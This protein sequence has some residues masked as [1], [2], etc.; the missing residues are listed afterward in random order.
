VTAKP[1]VVI[2]SDHLLYPSETFIKAQ[3]SA[4][5]AYEPVFAGSRRVAGL[6]LPQERVYTVNPG[7]LAGKIHE[8][9]FKI[10]GSAPAMVKQLGAL[11]PV[12]LHAHYGPNG[13]RAMPLASKLR[14]PL[15][16]TFHGSDIAITDLR[17]QKT[18]FGFRNYF[19]NKGKLKKSDAVFL[20]V[21]K[22]VQRKLLEQGFPSEKIFVQYTGVDT[23]K[24]RP[25][26]TEDRPIILFVGRLVEFKGPEFL[27]RAASEVQRQFPAVEVVLIGDGPLRKDL[28]RLAKQSLRCFTFL[29]VRTPEEVRD[30]MNRASMLC[31]PSVTMRSGEA[32]GYGMVCAEA[33]AVGKPV[34]A[35][36]SG[37][38]PE[39]ISHGVTGF[40]A[41]EHDWQALARNLVT[42]LQ[43][44]ELRERFGRSA[45]E[46]M[47]RQF[48]LEQCTRQL[49]GVYGM[50][51]NADQPRE[52]T[53]DGTF[54]WSDSAL[55]SNR[56]AA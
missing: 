4:L 27:I 41:P 22:F 50:V 54:L 52:G 39:I 34:V 21:S 7:S 47:L 19:A 18:Y 55:N 35:F 40:L 45:R 46:A 32:E 43:N 12:L 31:M 5:S 2:F 1:R 23:W 56:G 6:E 15:I 49:E 29:G 38:I 51:V 10:L 33:Q 36:N 37:G 30:W 11:H 48:D 42:L 44:P 53:P 8:L 16:V 26:S 24:F 17:Y 14:V 13:L 9:R 28:E 25:A 20:A 3:A